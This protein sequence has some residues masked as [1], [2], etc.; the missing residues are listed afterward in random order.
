[1]LCDA[2][3][4]VV[5]GLRRMD[6]EDR[7]RVA[8]SSEESDEDNTMCEARMMRCLSV[9]RGGPQQAGVP[10]QSAGNV[11]EAAV[12][13]GLH[14]VVAG[15]DISKIDRKRLGTAVR[16]CKVFQCSE[17]SGA[18]ESGGRDFKTMSLR[19]SRSSV[20]VPAFFA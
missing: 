14:G 19:A 3:L 13:S 17:V 20:V 5:A 1:M 16:R 15:R 6:W 2:R 9:R 10:R 8:R 4:E 7:A 11:A 12:G 18:C